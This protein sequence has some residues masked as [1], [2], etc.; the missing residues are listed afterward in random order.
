MAKGNMKTNRFFLVLAVAFC[1]M[2]ASGC[3]VFKYEHA[4][5]TGSEVFY[6]GRLNSRIEKPIPDVHNAVVAA[7]KGFGIKITKSAGDRLSGVV[8]GELASGDAANTE[9]SSISG[10]KTEV[11][12]KVGEEGN[13]YISH[14]LLAAIRQNLG[15]E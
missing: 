5:T 14:R 1:I 13:V 6:E 15:M 12:I 8:L 3:S 7:Y 2:L 9:L 4:Q 10:G 11:S